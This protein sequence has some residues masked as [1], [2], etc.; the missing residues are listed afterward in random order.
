MSNNNPSTF[1]A[2]PD[3]VR[4]AQKDDLYLQQVEDAAQD[5]LR[6]AAGPAAAL[7]HA[8]EARLAA[9]LAYH[10]LTTG[11]G[12]QTLGEEYCDIVQVAVG[13]GGAA[14]GIAGAGIAAAAP[15]AGRRA[16]VALA[17][18]LGPYLAGRAAASLDRHPLALA[19]ADGG[20]AGGGGQTTEQPDAAAA[21]RHLFAGGGGGAAAAEEAGDDDRAR[22]APAETTPLRTWALAARRSLAA[23][24]AAALALIAPSWPALRPWLALIARAHLAAF[25]LWGAF[26]RW[27]LRLAGARLAPLA[28]GG[29]GPG[30]GG[31]SGH[32]APRAPYAVLGVLLAVQ[33]AAGGMQAA[34][35]R[36]EAWWRARRRAGLVGGE[37]EGEAAAASNDRAAVLPDPIYAMEQMGDGGDG[38]AK[39]EEEVA[40]TSRL[41]A[42]EGTTAAGLRR[43][44]PQRAKGEGSLWAAAVVAEEASTTP[45]P[46]RPAPPCPLCLSARTNPACTPC[47]HVFC[48]PCAAQWCSDKPEC[49]LCRAACAPQQLVA[50]AND[51]G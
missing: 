15:G 45:G 20:G 1:A 21:F 47:G 43:R 8:R 22:A 24:R 14:A 2:Q 38:D 33:L 46:Q 18:A 27:P 17:H 35:P 40:G 9:A 26:Y 5:A 48:W 39:E 29:G 16:A 50:L 25:Y 49:P 11:C 31:G 23:R 3:I 19:A 12:L 4:A 36:V 32:G 51:D 44:R 28:G 37:A 6:R 41:A 13:D 10:G 34:W 30:G 42:G 7:K